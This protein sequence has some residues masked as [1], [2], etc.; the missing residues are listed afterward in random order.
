MVVK[1][2]AD[3]PAERTGLQVGDRM[4]ALTVRNPNGISAVRPVGVWE[5]DLAPFGLDARS[6]LS[7]TVQRGREVFSRDLHL[8]QKEEKDDFKTV[9]TTYVLGASNDP[10]VIDTYL[11][12]RSVG[13]VEALQEGVKQVGQ[14]MSIIGQGIG[15]IVRGKLP[16]NTMG[17]PI[18]LFV[19]AEKSANRGWTYYFR[20]MAMISVNLGM[21]NLL[22]IPALDGGH[23]LFCAIEIV[24]RR[25]P[26]ARV[27]EV[28]YVTGFALLV[29]LMVLIF[30]ND[31]LRFVLG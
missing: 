23:L 20:T 17:G 26:S 18:M 28:A 4:L 22:P 27:R 1:I 9:H 16:F 29:V 5:I 6:D 19:I 3:T 8:Q 2:D 7:V 10:N 14:D 15:K 31:F 25:P 30:R 21:L 24:S 13:W 12:E 11:F